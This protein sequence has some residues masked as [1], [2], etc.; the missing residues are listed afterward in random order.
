MA[1]INVWA[2]ARTTLAH[3][4]VWQV[5][6]VHGSLCTELALQC[7][8]A[9]GLTLLPALLCSLAPGAVAGP[10]GGPVR[11]AHQRH[12]VSRELGANTLMAPAYRLL[13]H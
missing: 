9:V 10:A 4:T 3:N 7:Q 6:S 2:A 11:P 5:G 12:V 1:G 13:T 8:P